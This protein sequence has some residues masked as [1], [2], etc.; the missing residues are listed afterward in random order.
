MS[1]CH[2]LKGRLVSQKML[3]AERFVESIITKTGMPPTYQQVANKF[4]IGR[5][6][7]YARLR[8]Y[9]HRMYSHR[10]YSFNN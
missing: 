1:N 7:A 10:M 8:R 6:A 2:D 5:T 4:N 3:K 9:R